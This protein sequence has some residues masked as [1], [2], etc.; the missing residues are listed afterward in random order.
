MYEW[1]EYGM[2]IVISNE[3]P[4]V[5]G[6]VR[7]KSGRIIY[8][9]YNHALKNGKGIAFTDLLRIRMLKERARRDLELMSRV[10]DTP[11]FASEH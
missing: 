9:K 2:D 5:Y 11:A 4:K 7:L 6:P 8:R 10:F 1:K 3:Q